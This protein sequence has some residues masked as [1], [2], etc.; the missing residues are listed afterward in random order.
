MVL[1]EIFVQTLWTKE[2]DGLFARAIIL[3]IWYG[4]DEKVVARYSPLLAGRAAVSTREDIDFV[5]RQIVDRLYVVGDAPS[6]ATPG[7]S[8]QLATLLAGSSSVAD[9]STFLHQHPVILSRLV[10]LGWPDDSLMNGTMPSPALKALLD[11]NV[12]GLAAMCSP[13]PSSSA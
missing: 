7:L 10:C 2:L 11:R 13:W 5:A 6:S 12:T 4:V 8:R 9:I 3:P 1:S